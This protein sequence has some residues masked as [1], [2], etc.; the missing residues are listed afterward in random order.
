MKRAWCIG[1]HSGRGCFTVS[2]LGMSWSGL[3]FFVILC[4]L[5]GRGRSSVPVGLGMCLSLCRLVSDNV[6]AGGSSI[7][8]LHCLPASVSWVMVMVTVCSH[9]DADC[10]VAVT[11]RSV[12]KQYSAETLAQCQ[13]GEKLLIWG[14]MA[15]LQQHDRH[16]TEAM[17][18]TPT[19]IGA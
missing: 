7:E 6:M 2:L 4:F 10:D 11:P 17:S 14:A 9:G 18:G 5:P 19:N 13:L 15:A 12:H 1:R 8:Y 3:R 16:S